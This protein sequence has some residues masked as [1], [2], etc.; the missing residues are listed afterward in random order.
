MKSK[1]FFKYI[2][3]HPDGFNLTATVPHAE[4]SATAVMYPTGKIVI[5]IIQASA[6][7]AASATIA[8]PKSF[9]V[10]DAHAAAVTSKKSIAIKNNTTA[11]FDT[12]SAA[13][14]GVVRAT[15]CDQDEV[16]FAAGDDDLVIAVSGSS[17]GTAIVVLNI[18]FT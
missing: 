15:T 17:A 11:I 12:L 3:T 6:G 18:V 2:A 13:A 10:V 1:E 7:K 16:S 9:D 4:S 5:T 8:T 14:D